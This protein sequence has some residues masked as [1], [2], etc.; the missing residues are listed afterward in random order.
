MHGLA[1]L[2]GKHGF[3]VV[4]DEL[5]CRLV[6]GEAPYTHLASLP[7]MESRTVTLLGGSKT[8]SLTGYRVGVA[9]ASAEIVDSIEQVVALCSLRAPAYSQH[10]LSGW[11]HDDKEFVRDRVTQL[12]AI[13]RSTVD[14]LRRIPGLTVEPGAGTAYLW[15]DV[16]PRRQL[17]RRC[18]AA[19]GPGWRDRQPRLP[20]RAV[21][22]D[23][24]PHLLRAGRDAMGVRAR[25]DGRRPRQGGGS[26]GRRM[27][28]ISAPGA[29]PACP[30]GTRIPH[31]GSTV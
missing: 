20:V 19:A 27:R 31:G 12:H 1:E 24:L 6:Y 30:P 2:A 25:P 18:R 4:V 14:R 23:T 17:A 15:P 5:Y 9:V 29:P 22:C 16:C 13:Q 11:L 8:E 3:L 28:K 26:G 7:G 21:R 10:V